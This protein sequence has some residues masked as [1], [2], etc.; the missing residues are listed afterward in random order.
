MSRRTAHRRVMGAFAHPLTILAIL[1]LLLN[2]LILQPL[3]PSWWTG[4]IGDAAW[5]SFAP[6]LIALCLGAVL[7]NERTAILVALALTACGFV[8]LKTLPAFNLLASQ[9]F[10]QLTGVPLKLALDPT[11]LVTLPALGI[12]YW[13]WMR[14]A[15]KRAH[16]LRAWAALVLT[17]VAVLADTP[18]PQNLGISCFATRGS[19]IYAINRFSQNQELGGPTT[20]IRVYASEDGGAN[21]ASV[22][23]STVSGLDSKQPCQGRVHDATWILRYPA[24]ESLQSRV[25]VEYVFIAHQGIYDS[26]DGGKTLRQQFPLDASQTVVD[27]VLDPTT[28]NI[29]ATTGGRDVIVGSQGK[30][31]SMNIA[32]EGY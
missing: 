19:T 1:V 16:R 14:P 18:A 2:T 22:D 8:A 10:A 12:A 29:V 30:W 13:I 20:F 21:W 5:L 15:D 24:G 9:S 32:G 31:T 7:G 26:S 17:G 23:P 25:D 6:F 27:A 28:G 11:D 4:K 3:M